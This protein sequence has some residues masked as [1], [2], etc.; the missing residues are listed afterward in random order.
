MAHNM[1]RKFSD[2][3]KTAADIAEQIDKAM[4]MITSAKI[5]ATDLSFFSKDCTDSKL[6]DAWVILYDARAEFNKLAGL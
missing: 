6:D 4:S 5:A 1:T 2:E 3:L